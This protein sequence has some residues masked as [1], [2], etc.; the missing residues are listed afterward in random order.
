[1]VGN[2]AVGRDTAESGLRLF[3]RGSDGAIY[4]SRQAEPVAS[5]RW[6]P[7]RPVAGPASTDASIAISTDGRVE[8]FYADNQG[9]I[10][11]FWQ[12][13]LAQSNW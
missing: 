3:V 9:V 8:V 5:D 10:Q 6:E 12:I 11:H 13:A 7:F 1:L 4:F 2:P